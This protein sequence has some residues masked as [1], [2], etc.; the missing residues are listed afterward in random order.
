MASANILDNF[1]DS[2]ASPFPAN[3]QEFGSQPYL[4]LFPESGSPDAVGQNSTIRAFGYN[5]CGTEGCSQVILTIGNEFTSNQTV[6]MVPVQSNGTFT[7]SFLVNVTVPWR[8]VVTANQTAANGSKFNASVPITVGISDEGE[9]EE[10]PPIGVTS[11]NMSSPSSTD[12]NNVTVSPL[13]DPPATEFPPSI[14]WGGRSVS[15]DVSPSNAAVAIAASESG[16]LWKT[17]DSGTT[18]SHLDGLQPFRMSDVKFAPANDQVVIASAWADSHSANSGGIWR[19]TDGG[20]TWSKPA[21]ADP[22]PGAGCPT[23]FNAWG[24][25]FAAGSN[26][27]FVGTSC[28][29]AVSH[30]LGVTWNHIAPDPTSVNHA[31]YAINGQQGSG[32]SIVDTLGPDGH[33]RSTD[34]GANW[35][36]SSGASPIASFAGVHTIAAS[37]IEP[38]VLFV[39]AAGPVINCGSAMNPAFKTSKIAYESDD[40][41]TTWT[42]VSP[43]QCPSRPP[44]VATHLSADGDPNHFEIYLSGGLNTVRQTCTNTGGPGLRCS[45]IAASWSSVTSD[46]ADHNGL[47]FS[48]ANNCAQYMVSDGGVHATSDCGATWAMTGSGVGGYHAL[49][50]YEMNGQVHPDHTDLYFGTQDND[51]W[52]SGD[53]GVTW[54]T[55]VNWEGWFIQMPHN[56]PTDSSQTITI[57]NCCFGSPGP[58]N[59]QSGAHFGSASTGGWAN[60][61]G[62]GGNPFIIE[63]GVYIQW[64][65]PIPG[66]WQLY[67]TTT[68]GTT[69]TAVDGASTTLQLVDHPFVSGSPANPTV[70]QGVLLPGGNVGLIQITG[71]RSA[72]PATPASVINAGSGLTDIGTWYMGQG[73]WRSP[74]VFAVD[75]NDPQHLIAADIGANMMMVSTD[76]GT[77]W[78]PD[79]LLTNLVTSAGQFR[80]SQTTGLPGIDTQAHAIAFDPTNGDRILVGTEQAGILGSLDGG[81]TWGILPDSDIV[82]AVSSFFFDQVQNDVIASSYGRGLWKLDLSTINRLPVANAQSVTT[83]QNTPVQ[84]TLTATDPDGDPVTYSIVTNPPPSHGPSHGTLNPP[85]NPTTGT[86]TYAPIPSYFGPDSFTFKATDSKGADSNIV[87][88]SITVKG[89]PDCNSPTIVGNDNRNDFIQGTSGSDVIVGLGGNDLINGN[90]GDDEICGGSGNDVINGGAGNDRV[91]GNAGNDVINGGAGVDQLYGL[92]GVDTIDS[93]SNNDLIDGG[94]NFDIGNGESGQD[95]CF[96]LE[97]ALSCES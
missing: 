44:W 13:S 85:L 61:P 35:T 68:T 15:V 96:N 70:Y 36:P 56:S 84:I 48:T 19:S 67:T 58:L 87:T 90:G 57:T 52:A 46:H 24:I 37:P 22:I 72:S 43:G 47:A 34:G 59:S 71:V 38:N 32:G 77:T 79:N 33:H 1:E 21:T 17:T 54:P 12:N 69:W 42:Q 26:D 18:W 51:L 66:T 83:N 53:N 74:L 20:S 92:D 76:G 39:A 65:A 91:N 95:T 10:E 64:S 55:N 62:G 5:F 86:V 27:V 11:S 9:E 3:D 2:L 78:N 40:G 94:L 28:G 60:P 16:G 50:I 6:A 8:Y 73:S 4:S 31:V 14:K 41:G 25:S 49:Q 23:R 97:F 89:P 88:V 63:P 80:F 29:V 45:N 82:P 30:D 7:T 81:A 75:P 93:G